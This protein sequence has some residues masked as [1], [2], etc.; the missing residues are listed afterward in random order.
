MCGSQTFELIDCVFQ[1]LKPENSNVA[2]E[3]EELVTEDI[4]EENSIFKDDASEEGSI[5]FWVKTSGV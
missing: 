4:L 2:S 3:V 5:C 1:C